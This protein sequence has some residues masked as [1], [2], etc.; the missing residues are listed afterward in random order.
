G[1]VNSTRTLGTVLSPSPG[2]GT[3]LDRGGQVTI[4]V[5]SGPSTIAGPNV[6]GLSGVRALTRLQAAGLKGAASS[7]ASQ[8]PKGRVLRQTPAG[9][10]QANKGTTVLLTLSKGRV[11]V[12]VPFV[13]GKNEADARAIL[14]RLLF[15][16]SVTRI[17]SNRPKGVVVAQLPRAGTLAPQGLAVALKVSSGGKKGSLQP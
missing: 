2:A 1:K 10:A 14:S 7:I 9:G 15:R 6:V 5:A 16:A 4:T 13:E 17:A 3:R 12:K 11:L 8:E